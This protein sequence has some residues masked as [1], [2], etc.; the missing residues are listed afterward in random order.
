VKRTVHMLAPAWPEATPILA[1]SEDEQDAVVAVCQR[2]GLECEWAA[3]KPTHAPQ[4]K[5]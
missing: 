1:M 4:Y 5:Y 2:R 3:S